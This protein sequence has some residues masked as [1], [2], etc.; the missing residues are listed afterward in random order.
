MLSQK[1]FSL[2]SPETQEFLESIYV[3]TVDELVFE[4]STAQEEE[5]LVDVS[6]SRKNDQ[7]RRVV[8]TL[9]LFSR[10]HFWCPMTLESISNQDIVAKAH[11]RAL[12]C[13]KVVYA[14]VMDSQ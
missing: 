2:L 6:V 9:Q 5:T 14:D 13:A 12:A 3:K 4:V 11:R 8:A 1:T 10:G 7:D